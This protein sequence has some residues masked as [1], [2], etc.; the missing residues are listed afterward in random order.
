MIILLILAGTLIGM[1]AS[2]RFPGGKPSPTPSPTATA[3][4]V[5]DVSGMSE[6]DAKTAIEDLGLTFVKGDDVSSDTV[7]EG[8]AV[9]SDPGA[10]TSAVLGADVTVSFSSG[11]ATVKVPDVTGMTQSEARKEIE[12]ANLA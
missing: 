11:S 2:G 4:T 3:A 7:D 12:N 8:L 9:S 5:P 1:F 10:G 6:D